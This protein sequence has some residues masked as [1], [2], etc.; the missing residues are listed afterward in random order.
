MLGTYLPHHRRI[1]AYMWFNWNFE[2]PNG[3]AD[4]PIESSTTA[5]QAFRG[6]IQSSIYRSTAPAL[7][8]LTKVPPPPAPGA[9]DGGLPED[10]SP[11]GETAAAAQ[12]AMAPDG[13][14]TVVWSGE[15]NSSF[16]VFERRIGPDG[17]PE[18]T[19]R[20]LSASQGDSFSPQVAVAPDGTVTVV[21]IHHDGSNF[22]VQTRRVDPDGSVGPG[23][24][25]LSV[26]GR[27]AADPQVA[28]APD[29]TAT[30]VWKRFDGFHFLVKERRIAADGTPGPPANTLSAAHRDAAAPQVGVA[31][32]GSGC[33]LESL[34]R[35]E[36]DRAGTR[37][38][39]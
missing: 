11:A 10:L 24:T 19:I 38:R 32:D 35:L 21:W 29:G 36:L 12:V 34:R 37:H 28:V 17:V 25:D 27:D 3:R 13:S 2:K 8:P 1:A 33:R 31:S 4:W 5:Q 9:G 15:R 20:Q 14:A 26:T 16:V 39:P 6:G 30:V 23:P 18:P 22:V 7:P